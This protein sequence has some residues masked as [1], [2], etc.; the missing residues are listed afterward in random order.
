[1][2][3]YREEEKSLHHVA[4]EAKFWDDNKPK[5]SQKREFTQLQNS[6]ILFNFI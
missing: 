1:M 3:E 2:L 5:T 4:L 6:S